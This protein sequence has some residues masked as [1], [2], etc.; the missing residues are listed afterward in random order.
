MLN[1]IESIIE[2]HNNKGNI[3]D[4][5]INIHFDESVIKLNTFTLKF[6]SNNLKKEELQMWN[7]RLNY[8]IK[9]D[10]ELEK[11]IK[12]FRILFEALNKLRIKKGY[13]E[14][15][16]RPDFVLEIN[17]KKIGI[18]ITRIYSGND[19]IPE[20]VYEDIKTYNL[21]KKEVEGYIEYRKYTNKIVTYKI[22][23]NLVIKPKENIL[24]KEEIKVKLKNKLLEKVRKM[25]DEY[26]NYDVN[27]VLAN[28]VS[29][30]Y[31]E[32]LE[33]LENFNKE[34]LFYMNH[35][36]VNTN[37]K[38]YLL[39]MKLDKKWIKYNLNNH[40]YEII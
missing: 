10:R 11:E 16:E 40:T 28:I 14:K 18:E 7:S 3:E 35:M 4:A 34:L 9:K 20:K 33:N 26:K 1:S 17:N 37:E 36:E 21:G 12:E 13:I 5:Y 27:I 6:T 2:L 19:W 32:D 31:F 30:E 24:N 23:E 25:F 38:E 8:E 39:L 15:S 29:K 22:K